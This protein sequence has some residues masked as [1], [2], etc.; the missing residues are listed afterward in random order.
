M[1]KLREEPMKLEVQLGS[2]QHAVAEDLM[3]GCA[4]NFC[5]VCATLEPLC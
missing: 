1:M 4:F 2:G 3:R 5:Y